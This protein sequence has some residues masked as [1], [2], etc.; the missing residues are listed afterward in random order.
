MRTMGLLEKKPIGTTRTIMEHRVRIL[1]R[2]G[3][4]IVGIADTLSY[5]GRL[6]VVKSIIGAIPNFSMCTL[7][8]TLGIPRS[9]RKLS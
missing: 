5:A 9:C 2:I 3:R 6:V 1:Q 4:R 7:N 8:L